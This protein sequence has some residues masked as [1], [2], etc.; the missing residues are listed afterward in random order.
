MSVD[1]PQLT[2]YGLH[3]RVLDFDTLSMYEKYP[4]YNKDGKIIDWNVVQF[5]IELGYVFD[6]STLEWYV[7]MSD[8][9]YYS[10]S[11]DEVK[12][13]IMRYLSRKTPKTDYNIPT[14]SVKN[15][16]ER[17]KAVSQA[18]LKRKFD[19]F[20]LE[21]PE[22]DVKDW[23]VPEYLPKY[24]IPVRNGLINPVN[25]EL[26]PHCAYTIQ[27]NVYNFNYRKMSED[28]ILNHPAY[29]DYAKI[30]PDIET[31]HYFLWYVGRTLFSN[32]L[33]RILFLLYGRAGTGKSTLSRGI[34][35]ILNSEGLPVQASQVD[36]TD[37]FFT[38]SL[39]G[40]RLLVIDE[41]TNT[42]GLWNDAFLKQLSGGTSQFLVQKKYKDA[43][44]S[45]LQCKIMMIGNTYPPV[46]IDNAMLDRW[47]I[48]PCNERQPS[49][50][51]DRVVMDDYLN[52][53]FNAA[54]YF[55]VVK[56]PHKYVKSLSELRTKI[57]MAELDRYRDTDPF[58]IWIKERFGIDE[59]TTEVVQQCIE[60]QH[61][62][63]VFEDYQTTLSRNG[64]KPLG[65][66][67]F[68]TKLYEEYDLKIV[69]ITPSKQTSYRGFRITS[70]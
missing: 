26:I 15:I 62:Q 63:E 69:T 46:K 57:M 41:L 43:Y 4:P 39:V 16:A 67:T 54:Y 12:R 27:H 64:N 51:R 38:S 7:L 33:D 48:I 8:G 52:W 32:D 6:Y 65:K 50:I 10:S 2:P 56:H 18:N 30:I 66:N 3:D 20:I 53:L 44:V 19:D 23:E 28:E 25:M 70:K 22:Y 45:D 1:Y 17:L 59:V 49:D 42:S 40:K 13:D 36:T 61:S 21:H 47:A 68:Y 60:Y 24:L 31:L 9:L 37:K 35:R 5:M 14:T 29:E 58:I 55:Y 34:L 11:E